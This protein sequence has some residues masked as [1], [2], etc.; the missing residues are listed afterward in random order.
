M[1]LNGTF[2]IIS[3]LLGNVFSLK[4]LSMKHGVVPQDDARA[5]LLN[6]TSIKNLHQMTLC[7]R[8]KT[9][10]ISKMINIVQDIIYIEGMWL[11]SRLDMRNC[12]QRFSGCT[13]F[14]KEALGKQCKH[15]EQFE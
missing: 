8:F 15:T 3:L 12:D 2:L 7:G 6:T 4:I 14:Y 1:D 13:Q 11:L 9:P 5:T 10:Y